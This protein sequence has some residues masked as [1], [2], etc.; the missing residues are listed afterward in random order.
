MEAHDAMQGQEVEGRPIIVDFATEKSG[1]GGK[2]C[3][4]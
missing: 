3:F 2:Y 4:I 1:G